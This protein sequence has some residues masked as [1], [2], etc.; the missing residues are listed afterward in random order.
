MHI[1]IIG[2][3]GRISTPLTDGLVNLG[4]KV[5]LLNRGKSEIRHHEVVT[6]LIC[7]RTKYQ[8]FELCIS[9]CHLFDVVID[10]VGFSKT[11]AE[12]AVRAFRGRINQ[13]IFC[14]A[15]AVYST[16]PFHLPVKE[17]HE[18]EPIIGYGKGKK[19]CEEVLLEAHSRGDFAV[20]I[21]RP[22]NTYGEGGGLVSTFDPHTHFIDRIRRQ[23]PI[24]IHGD[25][26]SLWSNC[27]IKDV[28]RTFI[29]A[30]G[31]AKTYGRCYNVCGNDWMTW[32]TYYS[33]IA[34]ALGLGINSVKPVYIPSFVLGKMCP[35]EAFRVTSSFRYNRIFDTTAATIDLGFAQT[36]S[37]RD[38][39]AGTIAW[40]DK[41][42]KIETAE[43]FPLEN[44]LIRK[45][46][47]H[48]LNFLS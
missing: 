8:E 30:I 14:S 35:A 34:G 12:S 17:S 33:E 16:P 45:W 2:G 6:N 13:Y 44:E 24:I 28:A 20:T 1:L 40:L 36:I 3:T 15:V 29:S 19:A 25:G 9:K 4:H 32:N 18:R 48:C 43:S 27:H 10:M 42:R 38:G 47:A 31:N 39:V 26:N 7:D 23:M 37:F 21:L 5:T 22:A 46:E 11:D 41:N